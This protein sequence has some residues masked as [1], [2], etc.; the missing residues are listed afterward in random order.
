MNS[1]Y[2][3]VFGIA[4]YFNEGEFENEILYEYLNHHNLMMCDKDKFRNFIDA[5]IDELYKNYKL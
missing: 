5:D 4:K 3:D 2:K 1:E